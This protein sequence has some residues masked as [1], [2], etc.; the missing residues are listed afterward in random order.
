MYKGSVELLSLLASVAEPELDPD[1]LVGAGAG[2][3]IPAPAPG[4]LSQ[5]KM[6]LLR[7]PVTLASL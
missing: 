2:N 5:S 3:F 4:I 6:D 7:N 1:Y